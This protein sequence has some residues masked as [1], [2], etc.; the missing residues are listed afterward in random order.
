VYGVSCDAIVS[1]QENVMSTAAALDRVSPTSPSAGRVALKSFFNI[2]EKWQC[3][4]ADQRVLLGGIGT[5]TYHKYRKLPEVRLPNDTL[6]RISYV[7]GIHKALR[8]LF[9][10]TPEMAHEW[11]RRPNRAAPFNGQ[12]ALDYMLAGQVVSLADTRRYLDGV[13]G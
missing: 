10:N 3:S 7:M 1:Q 6:E 11:V 8:I 12:S 13:R 9:S 2:M 4:A 5:T